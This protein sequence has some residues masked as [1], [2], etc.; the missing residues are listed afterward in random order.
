MFPLGCA[1][2]N[3]TVLEYGMYFPP[4][5][6]VSR[7]WVWL[8]DVHDPNLDDH[9]SVSRR[10]TC[11]HTRPNGQCTAY[12]Y[13]QT[14][15]RPIGGDLH[16]DVDGDISLCLPAGSDRRLETRLVFFSPSF[17]RDVTFAY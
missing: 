6:M 7:A 12:R 15:A 14:E 1:I 9:K 2:P 8:V 4:G 11:P 16:S 13:V 10:C 5:T 3:H 17:Q